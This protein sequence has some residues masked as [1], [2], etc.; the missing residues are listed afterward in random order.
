MPLSSRELLALLQRHYI[1]PSQPLPGGVFIPECGWN[2]GQPTPSR[3]DALYVGFTTTSGRLLVGH[4]LKVSRADWLNELN[5]P[6]KADPWADECH[7]WWLVVADPAIVH[8]GELPAGWGLM[9]PGK[10]KTRMTVHTKADTKQHHHPS[11]TAVRAII[12]RQDT[13][14]AQ[15]I[16]D[17]R[18]RAAEEARAE[19][20]K[21]MEAKLAFQR[22][23]D[24]VELQ[25]RLTALEEALGCNI[26]WQHNDSFGQS[27][28]LENLA[29]IAAVAR[30]HRD[31][32]RA[33]DTIVGRY[34]N[35]VEHTR[36]SLDNLDKR[37][38]EL[39]QVAQC[40][41]RV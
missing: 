8:D 14:R 13:L 26:D 1:K 17:I 33:V 19:A 38:Q 4:E 39:K 21:N 34:T 36:R 2:G 27:I 20:N 6:G 10:S 9:S 28:D 32:K 37:L 41:G 23:P 3:C 29:E 15:A 35:P 31:L 18:H 5:Q 22:G 25:R 30:A 11:W 24:T 40:S 7:Q 16:A 12:A